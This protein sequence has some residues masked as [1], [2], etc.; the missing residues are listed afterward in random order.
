MHARV[1]TFDSG[2]PEQVRQMVERISK[3]AESGPPEGVPATGLLML[4]QPEQGKVLTITLFETQEDMR[5]GDATL[6]SMDPPV[7]GATGRRASVEMYEVALKLEVD[8]P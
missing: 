2:D 3:Q 8:R 7:P 6:S 1:A 5:Q 4:H